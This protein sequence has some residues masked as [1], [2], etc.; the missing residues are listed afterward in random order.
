MALEVIQSTIKTHT[1]SADK[2]TFLPCLILHALG[3]HSM[4]LWV[5]VSGV[6]SDGCCV[7]WKATGGQW[8]HALTRE[9]GAAKELPETT[10]W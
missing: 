8:R 1:V 6:V 2:Q 3:K 5:K 10:T 7:A 9:H 4:V